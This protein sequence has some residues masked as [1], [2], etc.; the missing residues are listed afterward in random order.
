MTDDILYEYDDLGQLE[1]DLID[2]GYNKVVL[3]I[4]PRGIE[5]RVTRHHDE[6][7]GWIGFSS[8]IKDAIREALKAA[9][10]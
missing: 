8:C 9:Q 7:Y 10:E 6:F 1:R 2:A 4:D 5:A 3:T